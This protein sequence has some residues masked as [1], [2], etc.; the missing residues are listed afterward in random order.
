[1]EPDEACSHDSQREADGAELVELHDKIREH[2]PCIRVR[3]LYLSELRHNESSSMPCGAGTS[4]STVPAT[5]L[6]QAHNAELVDISK[7]ASRVEQ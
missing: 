2:L 5:Y 7:P 4:G 6:I 3:V 1:M